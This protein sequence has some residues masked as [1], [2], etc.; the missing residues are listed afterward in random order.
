MNDQLKLVLGMLAILI[1]FS[2]GYGYFRKDAPIDSQENT[3]ALGTLDYESPC[4][5]IKCKTF[6]NSDFG[7]SFQ[8]PEYMEVIPAFFP[9][10]NF[11][12]AIA[13]TDEEASKYE[14]QSFGMI[15]IS[16][17]E[18]DENQTA[19]EWMGGPYSG[20]DTSKKYFLTEVDGQEAVQEQGGMWTVVNTP[21]GK[22]RLSIA[23]LTTEGK[24]PPFSEMGI[25]IN[26]LKFD[27][28]WFD[29]V[30]TF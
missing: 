26:S 30:Q 2:I 7:F 16:V 21:D 10:D 5:Q 23:D 3:A 25:V 17:G 29:V 19:V 4:Y 1:V 28:Y 12:I 24:N 18:N 22:Y 27:E 20:R 9:E 6:E 11:R 14:G 15:I 13:Y 8:Y